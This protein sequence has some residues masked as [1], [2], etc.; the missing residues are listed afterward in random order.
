[1]T[2]YIENM[3]FL[4]L[5]VHRCLNFVEDKPDPFIKP[6]TPG[7]TDF[8]HSHFSWRLADLQELKNSK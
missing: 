4:L 6:A 3:F 5:F 1:M 8:G 2:T 7:R